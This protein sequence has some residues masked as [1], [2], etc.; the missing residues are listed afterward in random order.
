MKWSEISSECRILNEYQLFRAVRFCCV[1]YSSYSHAD[2]SFF[3]V[4]IKKSTKIKWNVN[5]FG[6]RKGISHIVFCCENSG[7][8]QSA[9]SSFCMLR[10]RCLWMWNVRIG[11]FSERKKVCNERNVC[12]ASYP[13][14]NRKRKIQSH[15]NAKWNFLRFFFLWAP[16]NPPW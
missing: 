15:I 4:R 13:Y 11:E 8:T 7:S 5:H 2:D 3:P 9:L 1:S 14:G 6:W 16:A 10:R 12:N